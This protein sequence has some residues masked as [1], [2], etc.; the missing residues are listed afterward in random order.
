MKKTNKVLSLFI[1][2]ALAFSVVC[3]TGISVSADA[4]MIVY[5]DNF[6][7]GRTRENSTSYPVTTYAEDSTEVLAYNAGYS[8]I[9]VQEIGVNEDESVNKVIKASHY[10]VKDG[11]EQ[12]INDKV[13]LKTKE[14]TYNTGEVIRFSMDIRFNSLSTQC[15]NADGNNERFF[16]MLRNI[17][18]KGGFALN[19][20]SD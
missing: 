4:E 6:D 1:S 15:T 10:R 9:C 2:I 8:A 7:T 19:E 20:T 13:A 16:Y 11:V 12:T 14:I 18:G 17:K 3:S 5:K